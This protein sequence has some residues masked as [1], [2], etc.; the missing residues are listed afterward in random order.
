MSSY[1]SFPVKNLKSNFEK[2]WAKAEKESCQLAFKMRIR[3]NHANSNV[4]ALKRLQSTHMK[5]WDSVT[6]VV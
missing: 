4:A 6:I 1:F 3:V 2:E 5:H